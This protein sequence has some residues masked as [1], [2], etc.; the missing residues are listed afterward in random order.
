M[1]T[2]AD[3]ESILAVRQV[4]GTAIRDARR[5]KG[6]TQELLAEQLRMRGPSFTQ[7]MVAKV[8]RGARPTPVE[9]AALFA[10]VLGVPIEELV[11]AHNAVPSARELHAA[12]KKT[13]ECSDRVKAA[14]SEHD[15][16]R[17]VLA[18]EVCRSADYHQSHH[19]GVTS[20]ELEQVLRLM[21]DADKEVGS[22]LQPIVDKRIQDL[23]KV[24][25]GQR[26]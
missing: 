10:D 8:E 5:R 26:K 3:E 20:R 7:T 21:H 6:W 23:K 1:E 4:F 16:A 2:S 24:I 12:L 19:A 18:E 15:T 11:A 22:D 13:R 14:V 25:S 9:E 17:K